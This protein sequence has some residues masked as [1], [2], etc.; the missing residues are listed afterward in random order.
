MARRVLVIPHQPHRQVRVRSL[1][2]AK[3]LAQGGDEVYVLTWSLAAGRKNGLSRLMNKATELRMTTRTQITEQFD[4]LHG[5]SWVSMPYMLA[6]WPWCQRFNQDQLKKLIQRLGIQTVINANAYHFPMPHTEAFYL[7]DVVDDHL[8]P[9]SGP[10]WERTRAFTLGELA[11]ADAMMTISHGMQDVLAKEGFPESQYVPNGVDVTAMQ[12]VSPMAIEALRQ[13]HQLQP[14]QFVITYIGNHGWWAGLEFLLEVFLAFQAS[15]PHARL[16]IVGP[17]EDVP[18]LQA[19]YQHES[20]QFTGPVDPDEV[21][22]YFHGGN[23]GV[24]PFQLCPFTQHAL[25]IKILEYG[26]ARKPVLASP[27]QELKTL[28]F[29]HVQLTPLEPDPW[30]RAFQREAQ[31]ATPWDPDWDAVIAQYDWLDVLKTIGHILPKA[32]SERGVLI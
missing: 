16:L 10:A 5:F 18:A 32:S 23:L 26:A 22:A 8:S 12:N 4:P 24:L 9:N 2:I 1:E 15:C 3:C 28:Q 19:K 14:D 21:G 6:P 29:P 13:R 7:Y 20:I 31:H 17:G 27:L 25:P 11:K 30:I